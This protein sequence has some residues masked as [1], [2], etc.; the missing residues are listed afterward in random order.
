MYHQPVFGFYTTRKMTLN[1]LLSTALCS[2]IASEFNFDLPSFKNMFVEIPI[3]RSEEWTDFSSFSLPPV[4]TRALELLNILSPLDG[5]DDDDE[6][7]DYASQPHRKGGPDPHLDPVNVQ[8]LLFLIANNNDVCSEIVSDQ[9]LFNQTRSFLLHT[10][11]SESLIDLSMLAFQRLLRNSDLVG[12]YDQLIDLFKL[13]PPLL[14]GSPSYQVALSAR[15]ILV[16]LSRRIVLVQSRE[17]VSCCVNLFHDIK[18]NTLAADSIRQADPHL[19]CLRRWES[20]D[21][22]RENE[23]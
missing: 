14:S 2:E 7:G 10:S 9:R 6:W 4:V 13:V 22:I 12:N 5:Q 20:C 19:S 18:N 17:A 23:N 3:T 1:D 16:I 15:L 8:Q 11:G 21:Y